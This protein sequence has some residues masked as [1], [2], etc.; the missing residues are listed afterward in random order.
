MIARANVKQPATSTVFLIMLIIL[1]SF[2]LLFIRAM[3]DRYLIFAATATK[4]C[5]L[6]R[7]ETRLPLFLPFCPPPC[8]QWQ[9]QSRCLRTPASDEI[10]GTSKTSCPW[11]QPGFQSR[12]PQP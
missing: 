10:A 6:A 7:V 3:L 5:C 9:G 2:G 11:P 1:F 8:A 4:T 12:Y